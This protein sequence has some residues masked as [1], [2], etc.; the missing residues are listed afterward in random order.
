MNK[1]KQ[2]LAVAMLAFSSAALANGVMM[3]MFQMNK[4]MSAFTRA[5]TATEFQESAKQFLVQAEKA[6]NTMPA[7]L[8]G[9]QERFKG[10]QAGMQE[11]IDEVKKAEELAKQD[12]LEEAKMAVSRLNGLKKKYHLEYK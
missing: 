10:Y 4:Y 11:V 5:Q 6:K 3:E 9:D 8:G 1:F 7:S 12:K 2:T